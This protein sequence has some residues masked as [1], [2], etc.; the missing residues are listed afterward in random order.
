MPR[1][2]LIQPDG[3]PK[4]LMVEVGQSVMRAAVVNMVPGIVGECGGE[5]TC[6]TCHVFVDPTWAA[7]LP[8][9]DED[10]RD[11]LDLTSEEPTEFSRL[12]CQLIMT[13]EMDGLVV[14][15]PRT[16]R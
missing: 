2:V 13:E 9:Q 14:R 15:L 4:D 8:R 12:S 7:H 11:M 5:L 1:L 6:A 16:Q 3:E 10:E